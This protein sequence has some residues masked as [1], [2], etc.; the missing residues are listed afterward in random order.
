MVISYVTSHV[1]EFQINWE[2]KHPADFSFSTLCHD[3]ILFQHSVGLERKQLVQHVSSRSYFR[4]VITC[5]KA[6][7]HRRFKA[8]GKSCCSPVPAQ[9]K[10]CQEAYVYSKSKNWQHSTN[11]TCTGPECEK[12]CILSRAHLG[13]ITYRGP[14][15]STTTYVGLVKRNRW[16]SIDHKLDHSA[17]SSQCMSWPIEMWIQKVVHK[18]MQVC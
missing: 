9:S 15:A 2:Q 14:W 12:G 10:W 5:T 11:T 16:C 18:Q 8:V 13:S 17:R 3:V 7:I 1:T 4:S 6:N